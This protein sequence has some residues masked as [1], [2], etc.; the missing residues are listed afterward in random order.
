MPPPE[1][2]DEDLVSRFDARYHKS[3]DTASKRRNRQSAKTCCRNL[4]LGHLSAPSFSEFASSW[5]SH[6]H[7]TRRI[8]NWMDWESDNVPPTT[9]AMSAR[10]L[11][12][13]LPIV[14]A[15]MFAGKRGERS[16]APRNRG[17]Q[18]VRESPSP[19]RTGAS[20]TRRRRGTKMAAPSIHLRVRDPVR[21]EQV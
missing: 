10:V 20:W 8:R 2:R 21:C 13:R 3:I 17:F 11:A 12:Q 15:I 14:W 6:H 5:F 18:D 19:R 1:D 16:R 4:A 7:P 9:R